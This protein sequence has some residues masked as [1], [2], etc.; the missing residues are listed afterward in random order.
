MKRKLGMVGA[1]LLLAAAISLAQHDHGGPQGGG[2]EGGGA[3][4]GGGGHDVGGGHIPSH[5]PEAFHGVPQDHAA[6]QAHGAPQD[7]GTPQ[8]HD[9]HSAPAGRDFRDAPGH[10]NAPH[11]ENNDHWVGHDAGPS[12]ARFHIDHPW[13]HGHFTGGFGPGHVWHLGGGGP[14][15]FW[16]NGFYFSVADPDLAYVNDWNWGG[17]QVVIYEDPDHTGFYLAY[18]PR[19]GTYVHV[20]YLG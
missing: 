5:G 6:P 4:P 7:H 13:A 8:A 14:S 10:P 9:S 17:D 16:F 19:L 18:N 15:R 11:V 1:S 12:D 2:H 20:T 3:P